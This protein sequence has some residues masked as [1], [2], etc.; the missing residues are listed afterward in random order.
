MLERKDAVTNEVPELC[1]FVLAYPTVY[2]PVIE[3]MFWSLKLIE[4]SVKFLYLLHR[5]HKCVSYK[6]Q[7][8]NAAYGKTAFLV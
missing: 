5:K 8:V 7:S 6:E 3:I 2:V 4:L 1:K